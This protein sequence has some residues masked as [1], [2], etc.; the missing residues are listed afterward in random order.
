MDSRRPETSLNLGVGLGGSRVQSA[1]GAP[2]TRGRS[3]YRPAVAVQRGR[4]RGND[5]SITAGFMDPIAVL[6]LTDNAAVAELAREV[7]GRLERV[8]DQLR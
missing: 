2:R 7:R 8:R 6:K 5:K 1:A 3:R 4:A